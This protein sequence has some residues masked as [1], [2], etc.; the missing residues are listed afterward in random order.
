MIIVRHRWSR[1]GAGRSCDAARALLRITCA[2]AVCASTLVAQVRPAYL[3]TLSG[4]SGRVRDEGVRL[5]VDQERE[6]IYVIYQNRIRI[7]NQSGME[8]FSFGDDLTLGQIV[9]AAVDRNGDIILLSYKD[10][11]P[12]VTRC[13]FRGVPV[14]RIEI[15]GLPEGVVFGANR[16]IYRNGLFYFASL[17]T[18]SVI[19]TDARGEYR[20]HID[21]MALISEDERQKG[22][23]E[24]VGF[25]VDQEGNILFT[26]PALFK[27]FKFSADG[28]TSFG[29]AGSAAGRFG[30]LAGITS[31]SRGN[32]VVADKLKC[33]VMVFDKSFNFLAEFG[34]RG[35]RPENLIVPDDVVVDRKD[36][37]YVSQGRRRGVSVFAL[38]QN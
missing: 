16:M 36:R 31:D 21:F 30:V 5:Y 26:M 32:L 18:S 4:F 33:V 7:F 37:V 13:N 9:D 38:A 17:A 24:M 1:L 10:S 27:V 22:G 12:S 6:E 23:A 19:I 14:G 29:R 8:I 2:L 11:R 35:S 34:Y 25:T 28:L 15:T 3:Y 20:K